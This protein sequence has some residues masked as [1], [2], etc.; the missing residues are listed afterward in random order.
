MCLLLVLRLHGDMT[1][2]TMLICGISLVPCRETSSFHLLPLKW[3]VDSS[4]DFNAREGSELGAFE[5]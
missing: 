5:F 2:E 1:I 3:K 4:K